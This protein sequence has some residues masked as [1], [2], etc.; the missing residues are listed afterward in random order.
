[1]CGYS[2]SAISSASNRVI[3]GFWNAAGKVTSRGG[4]RVGFAVGRVISGG[5]GSA[6]PPASDGSL[7][8]DDQS[9]LK[10]AAAAAFASAKLVVD[11]FSNEFFVK[12]NSVAADATAK[13]IAIARQVTSTILQMFIAPSIFP[14]RNHALLVLES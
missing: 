12:E 5:I 9:V 6:G 2:A 13:Q 8:N 4:T 7:S 11:G 1:M 14:L 10:F 3:V